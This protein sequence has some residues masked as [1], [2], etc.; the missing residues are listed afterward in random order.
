M[1]KKNKKLLF[2]AAF[3][4]NILILLII[5]GAFRYKAKSLFHCEN[6]SET[7]SHL[8]QHFVFYPHPGIRYVLCPEMDLN[9]LSK[10]LTTNQ[11]GFRDRPFELAKEKV[12]VVGIG[13]SVMM[14]WGV[15]DRE[16]FFHLTADKFEDVEFYNFA[17]AGHSAFQHYYMARDLV[18]KYRPDL[19][20]LNYVGNDWEDF[21]AENLAESPNQHSYF[22]NYILVHL[23][24]H[25]LWTEWRPYPKLGAQPQ[26]L[27]EAYSLMA[28][29]F[30]SLDIPVILV[31]DS[32]YQSPLASHQMIE[33]LGEFHGF[34]TLNLFAHFQRD[35]SLNV[36]DSVKVADE[37]NK[38]Y[39][40]PEDGH[41][42][43]AWHQAVSVLL[44][45]LIEK[46][47]Q[48]KK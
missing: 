17:I 24:K 19:I 39:L 8:N 11:Q 27:V 21:P 33:E 25:K 12:R 29:I 16:N 40:I 34:E 15:N 48:R 7:A 38:L 10:R 13:D 6:L 36:Q 2:G 9:F 4:F 46:H 5:E 43:L 41:P 32:R 28:D 35:P 47:L 3:F 45:P 20:V 18:M 30:K 23:K 31:M 26:N 44:E 22:F 1:A 42:N 37:H 14:G